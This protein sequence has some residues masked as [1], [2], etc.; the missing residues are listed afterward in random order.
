MQ[1]FVYILYSVAQDLFYIGSCSNPEE[2]LRKHLANHKGFTSRT[3]DW[4]ICYLECFSEKTAA[5]KREKQLKSWKS[6]KKIQILVDDY[7]AKNL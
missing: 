7:R 1:Y 5:V 6:K 2:R 4:E 3:K